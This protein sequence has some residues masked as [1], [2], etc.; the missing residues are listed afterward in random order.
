MRRWK[1]RD[2]L[3]QIRDLIVEA[4]AD[5][6]PDDD[7]RFSPGAAARNRDRARTLSLYLIADVLVNVVRDKPEGGE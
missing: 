6:T 7:G 2:M 4:V 1:Q 3:G 5:E